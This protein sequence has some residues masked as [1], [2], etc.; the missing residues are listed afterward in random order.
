MLKN[1]QR[2][3]IKDCFPVQRELRNQTVRIKGI[4]GDQGVYIVKPDSDGFGGYGWQGGFECVVVHE[5][6]LEILKD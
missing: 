3:K 1:N 6:D 2:V 4:V 5:I